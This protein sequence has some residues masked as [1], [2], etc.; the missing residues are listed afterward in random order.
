MIAALVMLVLLKLFSTGA[1][2]NLVLNIIFA[3]AV[4]WL[5]MR[6]QPK[7]KILIFFGQNLFEIYILQR[8]P[9]IIFEW[10]GIDDISI[11]L[12][13]IL[14]FVVTLIM[15]K[16]FKYIVEKNP[17]MKICIASPKKS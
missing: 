1:I 6:I 5:T 12:Y 4:V 13:F 7:N 11:I 16:P 8:I 14:C 17:L 3:F 15:I 9:M 2:T 10:L